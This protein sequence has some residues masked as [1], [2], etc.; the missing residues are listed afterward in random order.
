MRGFG[1]TA[2]ML[3]AAMIASAGGCARI[4]GDGGSGTGEPA[5]PAAVEGDPAASPAAAARVAEFR[6]VAA[7]LVPLFDKK[8]PP[9]PGDWLAEH[10]EPGQTL[11]EYVA[12]D[13]VRPT[14]RRGV[15]Y[16]APLGE[17]EGARQRLLDDTV[18]A[19]GL[20]FGVPVR[21]TESLSASSFPPSAR[22]PERGFGEQLLTGTVLERAAKV[23]PS[24][25]LGVLVLTSSDLYPRSDWNFVFG[26]ASLSERVGVWSIARFGDPDDDYGRV[27]RRTLRTALHETAHMLSLQHCTAY[28]CGMNG[29]NSLEESDRRPMAFCPEC[30][31]KIWWSCSVSDRRRRYDRLASFAERKGLK[32]EAALWRSCRGKL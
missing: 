16:V 29:S 14:P 12:S 32:E 2:T 28:E 8:A 1:S 11:D 4:G 18:E 7:R 15:L 19:L 25:A 6:A 9:R 24:D 10:R 27:L 22:R 13:P 3:M 5:D 31:A 21:V 30:D 20:F 23:R 26:Q 17:F